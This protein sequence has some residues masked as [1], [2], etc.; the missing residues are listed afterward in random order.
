MKKYCKGDWA[1]LGEVLKA[2]T[3]LVRLAA[4]AAVTPVLSL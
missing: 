2:S 3:K 4:V 1:V